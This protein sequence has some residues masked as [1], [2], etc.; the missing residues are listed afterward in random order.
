MPHAL[1]ILPVLTLTPTFIPALFLSPFMIQNLSLKP[2]FPNISVFLCTASGFWQ[3]PR[4]C[5]G[6]TLFLAPTCIWLSL[7]CI[8]HGYLFSCI[9]T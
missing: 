2:K 7:A 3:N 5:K 1:T 6:N 8:A 9:H 4:L